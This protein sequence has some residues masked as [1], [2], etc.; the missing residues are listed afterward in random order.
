MPRKR[1]EANSLRSPQVF[2]DP[3]EVSN[4]FVQP[5]YAASG[6][7]IRSSRKQVQFV[8]FDRQVQIE[9]HR[10]ANFL[11]KR[12]PALLRAS[13]Q[14]FFLLCIQVNQRG[15][16]EASQAYLYRTY[17][18]ARSTRPSAGR[19][20]ASLR[21]GLPAS[22]KPSA[23]PQSRCPLQFSRSLAPAP[24]LT[25]PPV[26]LRNSACCGCGALG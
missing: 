7:L 4:R 3:A 25:A 1:R 21:A 8:L 6:G 12:P 10:I 17:I 18:I 23:N 2:D 15:R 24:L 13:R 11:G 19:R 14:T 5:F 22:G 16:H 26:V 20:P 9:V